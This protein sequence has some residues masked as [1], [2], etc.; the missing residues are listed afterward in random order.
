M[1]DL[2]I[3]KGEV[4][5]CGV[6]P[7]A[8]VWLTNL[9]HLLEA[10]RARLTSWPPCPP[11][12]SA[13]PDGNWAGFVFVAG[14]AASR[15]CSCA[16]VRVL[17]PEASVTVLSKSS[18]WLSP[19]LSPPGLQSHTALAYSDSSYRSYPFSFSSVI[20]FHFS[21]FWDLNSPYYWLSTVW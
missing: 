10:P 5:F 1:G 9:K 13:L 2:L 8:L 17:S 3:T 11:A 16:G 6:T 20:Q 12:L 15:V 7:V 14:G 4:G 18:G 21:V 19:Q